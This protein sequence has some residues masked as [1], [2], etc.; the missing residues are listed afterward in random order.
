MASLHYYTGFS[1]FILCVSTTTRH[2]ISILNGVLEEFF[3]SNFAS[4]GPK[5]G[6]RVFA[7][8]RHQIV[9]VIFQDVPHVKHIVS[10]SRDAT[11]DNLP[12]VAADEVSHPAKPMRQIV[13]IS[14]IYE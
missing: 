3:F 13:L 4:I 8:T 12:G 5:V 14:Y 7:K 10:L 1:N 11:A 2:E 9:N 6:P